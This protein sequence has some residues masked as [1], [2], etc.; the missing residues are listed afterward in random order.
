MWYPDEDSLDILTNELWK[1]CVRIDNQG[2]P[3]YNLGSEYIKEGLSYYFDSTL[4][5]EEGDIWDGAGKHI[6]KDIDEPSEKEY[7]GFWYQK[8]KRSQK[9]LIGFYEKNGFIEDK[10]VHSD[11]GCFTDIPYPTMRLKIQ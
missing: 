3:Y 11:W 4:N 7:G 1:K 5:S 9:K 6:V 8:G 10:T 2:I